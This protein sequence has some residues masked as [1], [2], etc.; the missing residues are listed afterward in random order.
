MA[1]PRTIANDEVL[2]IF[3]FTRDK[4]ANTIDKGRYKARNTVIKAKTLP[5]SCSV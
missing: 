5:R 2:I 4:R 3:I 1:K